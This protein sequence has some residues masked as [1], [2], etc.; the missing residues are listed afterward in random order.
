M[1]FAS[2]F[3]QS[4][5][6][7]FMGT[8]GF[9]NPDGI[10]LLFGLKEGMSVADFGSGSGYF[11]ILMGKMVGETG[12][13]TALDIMETAL[14]S[15][16]VK[17]KASGLENIQTV[18]ANL[19]VLGSSGLAGESQDA[20]LLA[21]ILFQSPK[22]EAIIKEAV[23]TLKRGGLMIIIDWKKSGGG[24]GPPDD[25]RTDPNQMKNMAVAEGVT[26]ESS[27]DTGT[28]H[29]GMIFRK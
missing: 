19:E 21:N 5:V 29:Y 14:D 7:Q 18:R 26:F 10:V 1:E 4:G 2:P 8:G 17:A 6:G 24:F 11:T 25:L 28:F 12:K 3:P 23:R 27:I 13:V 9:M 15:V 20:V 16:R 22:K